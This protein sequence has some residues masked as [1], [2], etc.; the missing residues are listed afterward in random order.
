MINALINGFHEI[1]ILGYLK[2][3]YNKIM[4]E[5]DTDMVLLSVCCVHFLKIISNQIEK[6]CQ[7]NNFRLK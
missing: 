6:I 2:K 1:N 3:V 5:K 4:C 7:K